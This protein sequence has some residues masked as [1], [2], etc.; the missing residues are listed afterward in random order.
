MDPIAEQ[1][2]ILSR[3]S[4]LQKTA[5]GFGATALGT[6]LNPSLMNA[7][8]KTHPAQLFAPKAKRI[9][10]MFMAGGP[11]HIDTLEKDINLNKVTEARAAA[12]A[13]D[14]VSKKYSDLAR[15]IAVIVASYQQRPDKIR[16]L[17]S[18]AAKQ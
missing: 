10:Y 13:T 17:R 6:L 2:Q 15:D 7:G 16:Y 4:F 11:S 5:M 9:I 18:L 8:V 3:R 1:L 12:G 14:W